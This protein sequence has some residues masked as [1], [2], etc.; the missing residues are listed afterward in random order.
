MNTVIDATN[1]GGGGGVTHLKEILGASHYPGPVVLIAQQKI[2]NQVN[3]HAMLTKTGH[4]MLEKTLLHRVFFQVFL[5]DKFI[6]GNSILF[7]I[8]GDFLGKHRPVVSM[9]QNMLLYEREIWKEIKNVKEVLRFWINYHKQKR[10]FNH[11]DGIIFISGY[12]KNYIS[13]KLRQSGKKIALIHHGVSERFFRMVKSQLP[14][15]EFSVSNPFRFLYV[16]TIHVYKNQWNVVEAIGILRKKGYPVELT[17]AGGVIFEPAGQKL[18]Q[19]IR[20]VDPGNE[21]I[22]NLGNVPYEEI[23]SLYTSC[24]GIVFASTCENMPNILIESMASGVPIASGNKQPMPE[25]LKGYGFYFDAHDVD[26]IAAALIEMLD[27]PQKRAL[28]AAGAQ[29]EARQ[30]SWEDCSKKTFDFLSD[31]RNNFKPG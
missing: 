28:H 6:P 4:P 11:S 23:D 25:F 16:S 9:S 22:H 24:D 13:Q 3:D 2:L 5:I 10:S 30:Y 7:S 19:A 8:T 12:A 21:F 20:T 1:I 15:S 18:D 26:S 17:L 14:I 27:S 31:I 29:N